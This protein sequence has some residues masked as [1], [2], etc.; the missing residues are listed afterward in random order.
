MLKGKILK[1]H[2]GRPANCSAIEYMASALVGAGIYVL[3]SFVSFIILWGTLTKRRP[4]RARLA[5]ILWLILQVVALVVWLIWVVISG[6]MNYGS[7]TLCV[8]PTTIVI[9][10]VMGIGVHLLKA[11][12]KEEP[13]TPPSPDDEMSDYDYAI[14]YN[15][16]NANAYLRRGRAYIL[17]GETEKA[18]ADFNKVL[19][20]GKS[21]ATAYQEAQDELEKLGV[22]TPT[23][24]S[25]SSGPGATPGA[26]GG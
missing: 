19:M 3:Y 25:N 11:R 2:A 17:K 4:A 20:Q 1:I 16:A 7:A 6:A 9:L 12:V 18:I 14:H 15:P 21:N 5:R 22:P 13:L 8:L 24:P 26:P 10:I 23:P